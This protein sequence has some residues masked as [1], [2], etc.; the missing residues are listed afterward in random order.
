MDATVEQNLYHLADKLRAL[1]VQCTSMNPAGNSGHPTTCASCAEI[2]STLFFYHMKYDKIVKRDA[3]SD[4]FIL[5]KGH[6]APILY[7]AW[8]LVDDF[9]KN[10]GMLN[11]RQMGDAQTELVN[12]LRETSHV[13]EGHPT[14]K[15]DFVDVATGSL[16]QGLNCAVGMA[17]VGK[18]F[19]KAS[20][21]TFCLLGDGETAEG[22]IYEAMAFAGFY[23]LNNLVALIDLNRLGQSD[24]TM[25]QHDTDLVVARWKSFQW[26]AVLVNGHDVK[27]IASALDASNNS[28]EPTV[29]IC[30]TYKGQGFEGIA[31]VLNW[32]GKPLSK[33]ETFVDALLNKLPNENI[34]FPRPEDPKRDC[35]DV[36]LS[37]V[38]FAKT[39]IPKGTTKMS[40]RKAYGLALVALNND[41][42]VALDGDVKNST[43]SIDFMKVYPERFVE[44]YIAEQ[45]L[46]GAAIGMAC[47]DRT[48]AFASTFAAFFSRAYDHIRMGAISQTNVNLVGSHCGVSIGSDGP[49]QMALEDIA[50]FRAIPN[51]SVFYPSDA[52]S[53]AHAVKIAANTKGMCFIRTTREDTPVLYS[54]ADQ[55]ALGKS[56]T[57]KQ[58][59]SDK[60]LVIG[61]GITLHEAIK[62]YDVLAAEGV[63]IRVMD[64]FCVKPLDTAGI[65]AAAKECNGNIITVEDHYPEGGIGEAVAAA[66]SEQDGIKVKKLCVKDI[67]FSGKS[68]DL[69]DI[70]QI[71][72]RAIV[73][74]VKSL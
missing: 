21:K 3:H 59:A 10:D 71:N 64:I 55:F 49:S 35:P 67:P 46:V 4:R 13:L 33:P 24:P 57:V 39:P 60:A 20:Y 44:C 62:A 50:M 58:S 19:D 68:S 53:M 2:M 26:N 65:L 6:A 25:Y 61:A 22:S 1:C 34:A 73:E 18:Y 8:A 36:S 30:K 9:G 31:D 16:G 41:R 45:N 66:M 40:T 17:Y 70:F 72:S 52:I 37:N 43:F 47:R 38:E 11:L 7:A 69:L 29:I 63:Q 74:A 23:K 42:V 56:L 32:H 14:P 5:S 48:I 12:H 28:A 54:S 15:L 51:C 27:E